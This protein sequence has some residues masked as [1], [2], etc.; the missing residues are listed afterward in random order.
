[1][2]D[3]MAGTIVFILGT[4]FLDCFGKTAMAPV[5]LWTFIL[6]YAVLSLSQG[7]MNEGD[8]MGSDGVR[9]SVRGS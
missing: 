5:W 3:D 8:A 4:L 9:W 1:M 7:E 2:T 6:S